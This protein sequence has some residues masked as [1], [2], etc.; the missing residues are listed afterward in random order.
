[1]Q[2]QRGVAVIPKSVTPSRIEENF[3]LF[4]FTISDED[5]TTIDG[6]GRPD[7]RLIIPMLNGKPRDAGHPHYPFNIEF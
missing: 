5:V 1:M 2:I 7:G 6:F 3:K 4:D